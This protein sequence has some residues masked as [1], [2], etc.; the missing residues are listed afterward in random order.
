MKKNN[1]AVVQIAVD[2]SASAYIASMLIS[3]YVVVF[4]LNFVD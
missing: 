1:F 3:I 2:F 4:F